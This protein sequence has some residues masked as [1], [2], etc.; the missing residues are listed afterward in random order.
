MNSITFERLKITYKSIISS[1]HLIAALP[2]ISPN[3][4]KNNLP[5]PVRYSNFAQYFSNHC[6]SR[7]PNSSLILLILKIA[8]EEQQLYTAFHLH[9]FT[10]LIK[11]VA[12]VNSTLWDSYGNVIQFHQNGLRLWLLGVRYHGYECCKIL[13]SVHYNDFFVDVSSVK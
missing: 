4:V 7:L 5:L 3:L 11:L 9:S 13:F 6:N 12:K 8:L 10:L 2:K 1:D